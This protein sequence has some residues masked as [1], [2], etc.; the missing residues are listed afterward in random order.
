MCL[1]CPSDQKMQFE[2]DYFVL[3]ISL[4]V[5]PKPPLIKNE[6]LVNEIAGYLTFSS[7]DLQPDL[8]ELCCRTVMPQSRRRT[9]K[10]LVVC[11]RAKGLLT[12]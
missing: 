6:L 5:Y 10:I 1:D 8:S 11:T 12:F 7:T 3:Y 4:W 9:K 2:I